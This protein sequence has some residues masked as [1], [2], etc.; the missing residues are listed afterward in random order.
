MISRLPAESDL[1][2]DST[3]EQHMQWLQSV[4]LSVRQIRAEMNLPPSKQLDMLVENVKTEEV[5]LLQDNL[6]L[7]QAIGKIGTITPL[8]DAEAPPAA[9]AMLG[10]MKILIPLAGNIDV[11]EETARI[12]KQLEKLTQEVKRCEG[13]LSNQKF[14]DNAPPQLVEKEKEKLA[15][16]QQQHS[17]LKEQLQKL[18][19]L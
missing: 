13:K 4:I 12:T 6:A 15:E 5:Q 17:E 8:K 11:T 10:D 19:S 3:A 18:K 9:A 14:V 16:Y 1:T 2:A 7:L